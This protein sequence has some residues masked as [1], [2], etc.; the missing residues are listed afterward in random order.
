M[1]SKNLVNIGKHSGA[2]RK[3]SCG[4]YWSIAMNEHNSTGYWW[5]LWT[6][7]VCLKAVLAKF[8]FQAAGLFVSLGNS[9]FGSCFKKEVNKERNREKKSKPMFLNKKQETFEIFDLKFI[10]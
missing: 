8:H 3:T 5:W 2:C 1:S 9:I 6:L 10:C 4:E 7:P